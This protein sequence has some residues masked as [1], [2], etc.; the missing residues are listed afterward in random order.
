VKIAIII[1]Y[2]VNR[3]W[4][5]CA[6]ESIE[7]QITS[8][9]IDIIESQSG[10]NVGHNINEG[11]KLVDEDTDL[12]KWLCEDDELPLNA[13][14][15]ICDYFSKHP[16]VD[17]IHSNAYNIDGS[18]AIQGEHKPRY[19]PKTAKE[20][21]GKNYIHGGT[22]AYRTKCFK[23]EPWDEELWTGEEYEYHMRLLDKGFKLGYMDKFTYKYR[24]HPR[25]KSDRNNRNLQRRIKAIKEIKNR[26]K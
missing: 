1:P 19:T 4:L 5:D 9:E 21:A 26:Y 20:L 14:Q 7:N 24:R 13:V 23:A 12:V 17:F 11:F 22:V 25:Q 8:H 18:G 16:K 15:D 10:L 6:I 2:N 3:G